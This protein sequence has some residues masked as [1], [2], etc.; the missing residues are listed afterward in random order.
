MI[1]PDTLS[2]KGRT[3]EILLVEDNPGDILLTK[4]A[5]AKSR[6]LN[7]IT[8]ARSGDEAMAIL[9][10]D[11]ARPSAKTPDLIL[12]DLNLPK[13]SGLDVL[14]NVKSHEKLRRIPVIIFSSS[15]AEADVVRSYDFHANSY[16][17]KPVSLEA[18]AQV[19]ASIEQFWFSLVVLPNE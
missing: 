10:H 5:L 14:K 2:N 18:Y 17:M 4:R 11:S 1:P 7:N 12:L 16:I 19:V 6:M 3:A 9:S 15:Q 8:S 13:I